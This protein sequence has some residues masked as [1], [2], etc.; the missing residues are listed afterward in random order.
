M[1]SRITPES[2]GER[3][4]AGSVKPPLVI[5]GMHRSGT[6][7]LAGCLQE[8][9]LALGEVNERAPFNARGNRE[10]RAIM[11]LHDAVLAHNGGAWD[12]PP[13][14]VVWTEAHRQERDRIITSFEGFTLWGFKEPRSLL[15]LEGW[16]EVFPRMAMVGTFR[17]PGAVAASLAHRNGFSMA[18]GLTLWMA[19]NRK[20]LAYRA[21]FGFPIV[22]FDAAPDAYLGT[23]RTIAPQL[24]LRE[25]EQ[26]FGFFASELRHSEPDQ[27]QALPDG[28]RRMH[29]E[30]RAAAA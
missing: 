25:P 10:N 26:G 19:Y 2:V 29:A 12:A 3:T 16:L 13:E 23:L 4:A 9:G 18:T 30:L 17:H 22:D 20:L 7:C 21:R 28:V 1:R 5:L 8:A 27:E 14:T 24:G 15:V 6:S 11:D